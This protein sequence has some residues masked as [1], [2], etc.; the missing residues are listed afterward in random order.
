MSQLTVTIEEDP[1]APGRPPWHVERL[2]STLVITLSA[3]MAGQ[4]AALLDEIQVHLGPRLLA[5]YMPSKIDG[6]TGAD[7]EMLKRLWETLGWLGIPILP[8][9]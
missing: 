9:T 8:P 4:W 1:Q 2:G 7:A 6:A 5:I 3:P